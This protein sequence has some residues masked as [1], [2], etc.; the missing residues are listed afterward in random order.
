MKIGISTASFFSKEATEDTFQIIEE[1]G[2]QTCEVFLTTFMEYEP[3]FIQQLKEKKNSVDVY[4]V[5]TLNVQ[6]EPELFNIV[7]RTRDDS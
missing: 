1:M 6:F 2:I 3:E 4:S 7:K 5:H